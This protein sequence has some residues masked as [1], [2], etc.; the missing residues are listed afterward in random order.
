MTAVQRP[1][2]RMGR[3]FQRKLRMKKIKNAQAE[4][5]RHLLPATQETTGFD[6][7]NI[8]SSL[9]TKHLKTDGSSA[10][11]LN[12]LLET[13]SLKQ[14]EKKS[15]ENMTRSL[16]TRSQRGHHSIQSRKES[17]GRDSAKKS[18]GNTHFKDSRRSLTSDESSGRRLESILV[19]IV[20]QENIAGVSADDCMQKA[21]NR[22]TDHKKGVIMHEY[23]KLSQ[24]SQY[25][26]LSGI[27]IEKGNKR[28]LSSYSPSKPRYDMESNENAR[29]YLN[30]RK[31]KSGKKK[32]SGIDGRTKD[33]LKNCGITQELTLV[34]GSDRSMSTCSMDSVLEDPL[35]LE[36]YRLMN[37]LAKSISPPPPRS[38]C[39]P[40][41]KEDGMFFWAN[42][43]ADIVKEVYAKWFS[44]DD[45]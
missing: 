26:P 31:L 2:R 23:S 41:V 21:R 5:S 27:S 18:D 7:G 3:I 39:H 34:P 16:V 4:S 32:K 33:I 10:D 28:A 29:L 42:N 44:C 24:Q 36:R 38:D 20:K 1:N 13:V 11:Q 14:Q 17:N 6:R 22:S 8:R 30:S 15:A 12:T 19:K 45:I 25:T 37:D 40:R 35:R 9:S 43:V